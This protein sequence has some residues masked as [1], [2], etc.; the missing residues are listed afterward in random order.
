[1]ADGVAPPRRRLIARSGVTSPPRPGTA[2]PRAPPPRRRWIC[3][4]DRSRRFDAFDRDG[5]ESLW[6]QARALLPAIDAGYDQAERAFESAFTL[7]QARAEI[8]A[9]LA[10]LRLEHLLFAEDFRLES[11]AQV[12]QERLVSAD[13]NGSRRR[14]WRR[15]GR[16][17]FRCRRPAHTSCSKRYDLDSITGRRNATAVGPLAARATSALPAGS[18]RLVIDG[19]GLA[20]VLYPFEIKRA[21]SVA[22]DI[23]LPRAAAIPDGFVYV[24]AS[25]FWFGD[26]DEQ[27]RTQFLNTVPIHKRQVGPYL[28]AQ[29]E[30]TFGEWIEYLNALPAA[31][32]RAAHARRVAPFHGSLALQDGAGGWQLSYQTT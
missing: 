16:W 29:R 13:A 20:R 19:P 22:V 30:T 3:A 32:T 26:G 31:R 6:K 8:R 12:L 23:E 9:Q 18:Y 28:I 17:C 10:D 15:P 24:P 7:D 25:E 27:L 2:A 14:R 5:G 1:V 21:H 4:R 11:K